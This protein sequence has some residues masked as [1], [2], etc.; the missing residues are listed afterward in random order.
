MN[1]VLKIIM[2][3][4]LYQ[5]YTLSYAVDYDYKEVKDFDVL[6][7][8]KSIEEFEANYEKYVQHCLDNTYGGTGGIPCFIGYEMWD[9]ELNIYYKKLYSQ[10]DNNGKQLLK[11]SQK[12]WL[13]ERDLSIRFNS[14]LLDKK[15]TEQGTMFLLMRSGDA[16]SMI[17]PIIKQRALILK[18]WFEYLK[19]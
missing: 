17:T 3:F 7:S 9:R 14:L 2:F 1:K 18:K 13:K 5:V 8:F 6:S 4:F 19:K 16:D 12:A 15:Y 11:K 10:L